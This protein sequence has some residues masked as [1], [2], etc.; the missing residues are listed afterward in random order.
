M[1]LARLL[2]LSGALALSA[3]GPAAASRVSA[4]GLRYAY[5][6]GPGEVNHVQASFH[7]TVTNGAAT[8][9]VTTTDSVPVTP[10]APCVHPSP[11]ET[12]TAVCDVELTEELPTIDLGDRADRLTVRGTETY[13]LDGPGDDTIFARASA[14]WVNGP[15][16]DTYR[17]GPGRDV[18]RRPHGFGDDRIY[19]GAG[20]D[21]VYAGP[22]RD[23]VFGGPGA[24]D[25]YGDAGGDR[26]YGGAG[27]DRLRG[28]SG[29]DSM[30]GGPGLD[31]IDG[32]RRDFA[33]R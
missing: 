16:A 17:G 28:G 13:V 4:D 25:L 14:Q 33:R 23:R 20:N 24:D 12:R 18:V 21:L 8:A 22:G 10:V 2:A 3:A 30:F 32:V 9:H 26:L 29:L 6:A 19:G 5:V 31:R 15:G 27:G 11:A 7:V 1:R